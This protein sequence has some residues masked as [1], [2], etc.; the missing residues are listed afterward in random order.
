MTISD[1]VE[2][3]EVNSQLIY[4]IKIIKSSDKPF[5]DGLSFN[6]PSSYW[7]FLTHK[8]ATNESVCNRQ[9][10][11]SN[12]E[13]RIRTTSVTYTISNKFNIKIHRFFI[14]L[15]TSIFYVKHNCNARDLIIGGKLHIPLSRL[16]PSHL[17]DI[18]LSRQQLNLP[19]YNS[20]LDV[21]FDGFIN[22]I[23]NLPPNIYVNLVAQL[24]I[25][26]FQQARVP[27]ALLPLGQMMKNRDPNV[28]TFA[29]CGMEIWGVVQCICE[30]T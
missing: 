23:L 10:I 22:D 19:L 16:N 29:G 26:G 4:Y 24:M 3:P 1:A 14:I 30:G 12:V 13:Q 25:Q 18:N 5:L 7:F 27:N 8:V 9:D 17:W 11:I 20:W 6:L 28:C 2:H 21:D 15:T